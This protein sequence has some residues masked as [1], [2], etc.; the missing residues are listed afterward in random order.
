MCTSLVPQF[1]LFFQNS[2]FQEGSL[3]NHSVIAVLPVGN[4]SD[5]LGGFCVANLGNTSTGIIWGQ[6]LKK[7]LSLLL[8]LSMEKTMVTMAISQLKSFSRL[9]IFRETDPCT[10]KLALYTEGRC[11]GHP[12]VVLQNFVRQTL[13]LY[14]TLLL[15][16]NYS[17]H[18]LFSPDSQCLKTG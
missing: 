10:P 8:I 15:W 2:Y 18:S 5:T 1:N 3:Q 4:I 13:T 12:N 9:K 16:T 14:Y 6:L 17:T 11:L 7:V